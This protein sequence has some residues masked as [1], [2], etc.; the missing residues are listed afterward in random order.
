MKVYAETSKVLFSHPTP[1][2]WDTVQV[3]SKTNPRVFYTVD[4]TH[5]RCSCPSWVF[6]KT[7]TPCKH[8]RA[9]GFRQIMSSDAN[10]KEQVLNNAVPDTQIY[11]EEL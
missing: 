9:L 2:G 1:N 10:L 5:G 3:Q 7:K 8:L 4:L 6:S 11:E